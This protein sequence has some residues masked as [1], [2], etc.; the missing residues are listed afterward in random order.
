MSKEL[1]ALKKLKL[2]HNNCY[3]LMIGKVE[4]DKNVKKEF[5]ILETA[6]KALEFLKNNLDVEF[7]TIDNRCFITLNFDRFC[8]RQE[9]PKQEYD[10][11]KEVLL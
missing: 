11:L 5:D 10:L 6:L 8:A 7:E 2:N 1:E 3:T 9:L 4:E